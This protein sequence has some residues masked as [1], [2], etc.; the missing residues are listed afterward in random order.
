MPSKPSIGRVGLLALA[1][2]AVLGSTSL[3]AQTYTVQSITAPDFATVAAATVGTTTFQNNGSVSTVSG[4]GAYVTGTVTRGLV[5]IRC[6]DGAGA[7][8][9]CNNANNKA[10]VTVTTDGSF[11]GRAQGLTSFTAVAGSGVTLTGTTTGASLDLVMAGW[12]ANNQNRTFSLNVN[13]P[14]LGDNASTATS[15]ASG[16]RV[17][18]ALNPTVPTTGASSSAIATVRR[19][20]TVTKVKDIVFGTIARP[21]SSSGT[22]TI[23]FSVTAPNDGTSSRSVGGAAPP[24]IINSSYYSGGLFTLSSEPGTV[25]SLTA[26]TAATL[27]G[28]GGSISAT[29]VPSLATGSHSMVPGGIGLGYGATI[30]VSSSTNSG[31]YSGS[32]MVS[33]SYN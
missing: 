3:R 12:T 16:F 33:I 27:T 1:I 9:R 31:S 11:S 14:I 17:W 15:A 2:P 7:A 26:P 22:V 19:S 20:A 29:L 21:T 28:P 5:T 4:N 6:A 13:L 25:F 18:A 23:G 8:R 24:G 30:T 32:F 10:R